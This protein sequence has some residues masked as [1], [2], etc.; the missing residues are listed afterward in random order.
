VHNMSLLQE[1]RCRK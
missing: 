1:C